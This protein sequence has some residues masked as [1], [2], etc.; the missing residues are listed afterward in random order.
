MLDIKQ[1]RAL[2]L[3]LWPPGQ[4]Y[5][6]YTPTS[7]VSRFLDG[8]AEAVKTFGYDIVDRLR[9]EMN[10]ATAVDKLADW[11]NALAIA[12][13]YTAR[14]GTVA[15]RQGAVV[16]KLREFGAFTLGNTRAILA[17]LLGYVDTGKLVIV[18]TDRAKMRAAHTY[19]NGQ[20]YPPA[21]WVVA[22]AY[23]ADGGTVGR[24]GVQLDLQFGALPSAPFTLYLVA[25]SGRY[26]SWASMALSRPSL[27]LRLYA[28][29]LTGE[30]CLGT[31]TLVV[32]VLSFAQRTPPI[33]NWSV[34]VEGTGRDG[35]S[36][37][38]CAWGAFLDPALAGKSGAPADPDGARTAIS[39]IE[40]AHTNGVLLTSMLAIPDD[41][42]SLPDA[43]LP[44]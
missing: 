15:Q 1:V 18:E 5:D 23:V 42:N 2:L 20:S 37:D 13:S 22:S 7:K 11:E 12:S 27:K 40:H 28:P 30:R 33:T 9:R 34:F 3:Q 17:A 8:L 36:K 31:W 21:V 24:A 39:S 4:L 43:C 44:G 38:L 10:P 26:K 6:W 29:E 16:A 19:T 25:P 41:P 35:L 14:F 32:I